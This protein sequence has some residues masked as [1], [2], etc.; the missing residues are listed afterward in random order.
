[1]PSI[2]ISKV[3]IAKYQS[4]LITRI[5]INEFTKNDHFWKLI[6]TKSK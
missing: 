3:N 5:L 2:K 1:M 4:D 6:K